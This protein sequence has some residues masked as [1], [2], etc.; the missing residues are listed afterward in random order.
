[1]ARAIGGKVDPGTRPPPQRASLVGDPGLS[2]PGT[3]A[4]P[5]RAAPAEEFLF[6]LHRGSE[7]LISGDEV[8]A[9][10][11]LERALG[12]QPL[13]PQSEDLLGVVYFRLGLYE[14]AMAI[15]EK[16]TRDHSDAPTLHVNLAL[17]YLKTG[18]LQLA[19]TSL[20][21]AIGLSPDHVRAHAYRGLVLSRLGE[22][23]L[24][25][26]SF[27]R[28]GHPAMARRM[29]RLARQSAGGGR[30]DL[31]AVAR[32]EARRRDLRRLAESAFQELDAVD[33]PFHVEL[34]VPRAPAEGD[35][36]RVGPEPA[37]PARAPL[38]PLAPRRDAADE[39]PPPPTLSVG[40]QAA[41]L[42]FPEAGPFAVDADGTLRVRVGG[43][44]LCR[45][46]GLRVMVGELATEPLSR[47]TRGRPIEG[48]EGSLGPAHAP[49]HRV[50]GEGGL[51]LGPDLGSPTSGARWGGGPGSPT[52]GARWGGGGEVFEPFRIEDEPVYLREELLVAIDGN[53]TWENGRL[54][55]GEGSVPLVNLRGR[56]AFVLAPR[57][58]WR[59]VSVSR[60][61][62]AL[63]ALDALLGWCGRLLPGGPAGGQSGLPEGLVR[64]QGEGVLLVTM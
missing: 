36:Q 10:D 57:A 64:F 49:L 58:P 35:W 8:G 3:L 21:R 31:D 18:Q 39:A 26:D 24:A 2:S 55:V 4:A 9:K 40:L 42:D 33:N 32:D 53:V 46:H 14:R 60:G 61:K 56:G 43:A 27:E 47:R 1:M 29:D 44:V 30:V 7:L 23:D 48:S 62:T 41:A 50:S 20:E 13:D 34:G 28:G 38:A 63:V 12:M 45:L 11:E 17:V 6:H 22:F 5:V 59:A 25:R 54:P 52:S 37:L 19:R 51:V 15:Y 16:L